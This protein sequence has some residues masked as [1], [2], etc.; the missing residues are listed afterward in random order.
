MGV[1]VELQSVL[2][3]VETA[4]GRT[5]QRRARRRR[6]GSDEVAVFLAVHDTDTGDLLTTYHWVRTGV[7]SDDLLVVRHTVLDA[8]GSTDDVTVTVVGYEIDGRGSTEKLAAAKFEDFR[9]SVTASDRG[10]ALRRR[11]A[12]TAARVLLVPPLA[13]RVLQDDVIML[14]RFRVTAADVRGPA[15]PPVERDEPSGDVP[16]LSVEGTWD[17]V[18]ALLRAARRYRSREEHSSYLVRLTFEL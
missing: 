15:V 9:Q 4:A 6:R 7:D 18:G 17:R 10:L 14:D 12:R 11:P 16:G 8:A 3:E 13:R 2:C 1:G 5:A